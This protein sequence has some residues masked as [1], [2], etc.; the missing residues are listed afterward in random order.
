MVENKYFC[1]IGGLNSGLKSDLYKAGFK[2]S[3]EKY[4]EALERFIL[5]EIEERCIIKG[6]YY[7]ENTGE[8]ITNYIELQPLLHDN[9]TS[10]RIAYFIAKEL[11]NSYNTNLK[12]YCFF[13][14]TIN[15]ANVATNLSQLL[16]LD[17]YYADRLDSSGEIRKLF[18]PEHIDRERGCIVVTDMVCLGHELI[19][20]NDLIRM[21][22]GAPK[23]YVGVIRAGLD[24]I[25]GDVKKHFLIEFTDEIREKLGYKV[26]IGGIQK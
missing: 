21:M 20:A 7:Q 10:F 19:R 1:N 2:E 8:V 23:G 3:K 18:M 24:N 14:H 17:I 26:E 22:G 16:G 12:D 6:K 15:G 4:K 13:C 5:S 25:S 9:D 11:S